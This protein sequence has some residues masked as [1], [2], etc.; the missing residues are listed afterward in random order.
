MTFTEVLVLILVG[1]VCG[2]I[3]QSIVD[4]GRGGLVAATVAG[5][6]GAWIGNWGAPQLHLPSILTVTAGGRT[7][8]VLWAILGAVALLLV[9]SRFRR[10]S[11]TR[12]RHVR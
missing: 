1:A 4:W 2:S 12:W 10:N 9:L 3:A 8:E 7:I 5:F 6:A 11:F